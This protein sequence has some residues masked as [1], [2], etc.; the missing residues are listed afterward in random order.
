MLLALIVV[1]IKFPTF[2]SIF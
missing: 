2:W 1:W